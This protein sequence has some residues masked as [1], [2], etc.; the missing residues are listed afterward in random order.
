MTRRRI[1]PAAQHAM[2]SLLTKAGLLGEFLEGNAGVNQIAQDGESF[3][4]LAFKQ[5]VDGLGIQ[6]F[7]KLRITF[8]AGQHSLFMRWRLHLLLLR[9]G[10]FVFSYCQRHSPHKQQ[11][12]RTGENSARGEK[13]MIKLGFAGKMGHKELSNFPPLLRRKPLTF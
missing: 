3:F 10:G 11:S 9:V 12:A 8:D 1:A 2:Q 5:R 6:R 13:E 7:R 4:R